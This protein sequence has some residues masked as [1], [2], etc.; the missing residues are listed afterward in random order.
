MTLTTFQWKHEAKNVSV[1]GSF[2]NWEKIPLEKSCD[3]FETKIKLLPGTYEYKFILNDSEWCYDVDA[4]WRKDENDIINNFVVVEEKVS[5]ESSNQT[6]EKLGGG[7][8][9]I[10]AK[11]G[12]IE[13]KNE[14][15]KEKMKKK[16]EEK[17]EK[18]KEKKEKIE[19]KIEE[20]KE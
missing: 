2:S 3:G 13:G 1:A 6:C 16:V 10:E 4:A 12:K 18:I 20:K 7:K 15:K 11:T 9:E 5:V 14:E 17:K 8:G 19:E